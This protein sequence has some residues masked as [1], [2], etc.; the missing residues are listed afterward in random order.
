MSFK[1]I[2]EP[3]KITLQE[4]GFESPLPLQKLIWSKIKGG[5]S[6]FCIAPQN[7][8]KTTTIILSVIQK[9]NGEA[10]EDAP[11]ALIFVKD[12]QAALDLEAEFKTY[13]RGTDLRIYCAYDEYNIELQR[14]DLYLGTDI[15]IATP[16]RLNKIFYLNGINL[17]K[18]QMFIVDDA[19]FLFRNSNFEEVS[20]TPES[21]EKCQYLIFS[22]KFDMRFERWK[23]S[24]MF[25]SQT[26]LF[27]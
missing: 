7:S 12:K 11:R 4:K 14:E 5:S 15:V 6:M 24:F 19:E 22:T 3:L 9:L 8:G 1:K 27:K 20:R 17:N 16:K 18:L 2:I 25:N 13:T 23:D 21:L 26:I 10:F